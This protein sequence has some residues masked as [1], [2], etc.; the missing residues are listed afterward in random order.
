MKIAP[1]NVRSHNTVCDAVITLCLARDVGCEWK[2]PRKENSDHQSNSILFPFSAP[3]HRPSHVSLLPT[4]NFFLQKSFK[5]K[6]RV[7]TNL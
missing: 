7:P 2:G 5:F 3:I 6:D 1:R 4:L